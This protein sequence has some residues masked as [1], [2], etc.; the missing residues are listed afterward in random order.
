MTDLTDNE[1]LDQLESA[2]EAMVN[3]WY[4][5][6]DDCPEDET[7]TEFIQRIGG[8]FVLSGATHDS[9]ITVPDFPEDCLEYVSSLEQS[10][11]ALSLYVTQLEFNRAF[12]EWASP[13][14]EAL[15]LKLCESAT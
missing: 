9:E 7:L 13:Q 14:F 4:E 6:C 8:E 10:Q 3:T 2:Q 5:I 12:D 1:G 15:Q 11:T